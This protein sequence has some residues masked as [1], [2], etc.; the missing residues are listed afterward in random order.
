MAMS[1]FDTRLIYE[2][3]Q[4]DRRWI[5]WRVSGLQRDV[6][7]F[8]LEK[9][10]DTSYLGYSLR[11]TYEAQLRAPSLIFTAIPNRIPP[12][13]RILLT[14]LISGTYSVRYRSKIYG[15]ESFI[16]II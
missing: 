7:Y 15:I 12:I 1:N 3:A 16:M 5:P 13:I 2:P 11:L 4:G 14:K 9:K 6:L 10:K 8:N